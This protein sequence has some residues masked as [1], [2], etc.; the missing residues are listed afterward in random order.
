MNDNN[1]SNYNIKSE[2]SM[3]NNRGFNSNQEEQYNNYNN[4]YYQNNNSENFG[5]NGQSKI[6]ISVPNSGAILTLGIISIISIC[7]CG[8]F[9]SPIL[10]I[11]ALALVP[12]AKRTYNDNPNLYTSTSFSNIKAGQT[13]AIIGLV[14]SV[15]LFFYFIFVMS[16]SDGF[17][18]INNAINDVWNQSNY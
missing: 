8:F 9:A 2:N 5:N 13:C 15:F 11:I 4:Q 17:T 3:N 10:A 14:V 6:P 1:F 18:E 7:C 16:F 12:K